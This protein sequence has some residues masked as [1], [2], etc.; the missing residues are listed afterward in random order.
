MLPISEGQDLQ[1]QNFFKY[2]K[3]R[4]VETFEEATEKGIYDYWLTQEDIADIARI[5]YN[6]FKNPATPDLFEFE[7]SGSISQLTEQIKQFKKSTHAAE[8]RL[9]LIVNLS[10]QHWVTLILSRHYSTYTGLY[11]DSQGNLLSAEYYAVLNQFNIK[12]TDFSYLAQQTDDYNCGLWA[13]ENAADLNTM[14]NEA[15]PFDWLLECFKRPRNYYYFNIVRRALLQKFYLDVA[16]R[17]RLGSY[18]EAQAGPTTKRLKIQPLEKDNVDVRL[19]NFV[20]SF[21]GYFMQ[22]L[23]AF[24]LIAR[25][26]KLTIAAL[27]QELKTGA[28]GA[29]FGL[30]I[31]R[32]LPGTLPSLVASLRTISSQYYISKAKARKITRAFSRMPLGALTAILADA[33]VEIFK[34]FEAQFMHVTDKA[35]DKLAMQK[36]AE[37]A[38]ARALNYVS[39]ENEVVRVSMSYITEAIILGNSDKYFDPDLKKFRLSILGNAIQDES[40]NKI[41]T[42]DLFEKVGLFV[43]GSSKKYYKKKP[44]ESDRYGYRCVLSWEKNANNVLIED[45]AQDYEQVI[46]PRQESGF[47]NDLQGYTYLLQSATIQSKAQSI[48]TKIKNAAQDISLVKSGIKKSIIFDLRLPVEN[49]VG[50]EAALNELHQTLLLGKTATIVNAMSG[51]SLGSAPSLE[52]TSG[53]Q[54]AVSGLGGIGKTQLA[55]RYAQ[56]HVTEYD[57]N[58]VWINS[59]T[60]LDMSRSFS[61]LAAKLAIERKDEYGEHK[62]IERIVEEIY[63]YFSDRRSLFI[64]DNVENY[65]EI[66]PFLPKSM[67][68]NKPSLLITSRYKNWQNAAPVVSLDVFTNQESLALV[69]NGLSINSNSQDVKIQLLH[70]LLHGLPLALQQAIAYIKIQRNLD[71]SFSIGNYI[72]MF[73]EKT[74]EVLDFNFRSYS[75]DP[76]LKTVYMTWKITLERIK[77]EGKAGEMAI[78]I[79]NI[80]SFIFPE[81]ISTETFSVFYESNLLNEA[82]HLL[83]VYSMTDAGSIPSE[84]VVHRLMQKVVNLHLE[85]NIA[86]FK[87][88][89]LQAEVLVMHYEKNMETRFHYIYF[90]LNIISHPELESELQVKPSFKQISSILRIADVKMWNYFLDVSYTKFNK[91]KY[92]EF[93]TEAFLNYRKQAV[94]FYVLN[95]LQYIEKK[96]AEEILSKKDIEA[97]LGDRYLDFK[98]EYRVNTL[99]TE[100]DKRKRQLYVI[101][102]ISEFKRKIF[103]ERYGQPCQFNRKKRSAEISC[104]QQKQAQKKEKQKKAIKHLENVGHIARFVSTGLFAKDTVAAILRGDFS[105]VAINFSLLL[106]GRFFGKLSNTLLAQ[107]EKLTAGESALLQKEFTLENKAALDIF[108]H[109]EVILS[110]KR[111]LLSNTIKMASPFIARGT[112]ILFAYNLITDIQKYKSGDT[113]ALSSIVSNGAIV[114]ID[115]AE[116]SVEAAEFLGIITGVSEFTGPV[117]EGIAVLIWL[118]AEGYETYKELGAIEKYVDLTLSDKFIQGSRVFFGLNP[119][120]YIELKAKN[121]QLIQ[122]AVSFL[123][124]HRDVKRYVFSASSTEAES[125]TRSEVHLDNKFNLTLS[126]SMPDVPSNT[127]LFCVSGTR[128]VTHLLPHLGPQEV[129]NRYFCKK[130]IGIEYSVNRTGDA[131]LIALDKGDDKAIVVS[132]IPTIFLVNTGNKVYKGNDK[133]NLFFLLGNNITGTLEGGNGI[134]LVLLNNFYADTNASTLIDRQRF[135][136][137]KTLAPYEII[138]QC[139]SLNK[140]ALKNINQIYG[141]PNK[142]DVLYLTKDITFVDGKGGESEAFPDIIYV[143]GEAEQGLK[144]IVSANTQV[145]YID[146]NL[147][148]YPVDHVIPNSQQGKAQIDFPFRDNIQPRFFFDYYFENL[149]AIAIDSHRLQ[150]NFSSEESVA[151][152]KETFSLTLQN[153]FTRFPSN[154]TTLPENVYYFFKEGIQIKLLDENHVYIKAGS[155]RKLDDIIDSFIVAANRL[156]KTFTI[157]LSHNQTVSIGQEKNEILITNCLSESYLI[158]NGGENVC[159]VS[160]LNTTSFPLPEVTLYDSREDGVEE[161]RDTLDLREV[162][163]KINSVCSGQ[164]LSTTLQQEGNDLVMR[165]NTFYYPVNQSQECVQSDVRWAVI[166]VRFKKAILTDWCQKIDVLLEDNKPQTIQYNTTKGWYLTGEAITFAEDKEIIV[167]TNKDIYQSAELAILKNVGNFTFLNKNGTDLI[168]TNVLDESTSQYDFYTIIFSRFYELSEMREKVLSLTFLFLDQEVSL[169]NYEEQINTTLSFSSVLNELRSVIPGPP[170]RATANVTDGVVTLDRDK[171]Q[172][173]SHV[174]MPVSSSTSATKIF[175]PFYGLFNW[176]MKQGSLLIS[177]V[178]NYISLVLEDANFLSAERAVSRSHRV[179]QRSVHNAIQEEN[180]DSPLE[181]LHR[182][183]KHNDSKLLTQKIKYQKKMTKKFHSKWNKFH[184]QEGFFTQMYDYQEAKNSPV[185]LKQQTNYKKALFLKRDVLFYQDS[186]FRSEKFLPQVTPNVDVNETLVFANYLLRA[187]QRN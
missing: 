155:S 144:I 146:S 143:T 6:Y 20:E 148:P 150:F 46:N 129:L 100:P 75:N 56:L 120:E 104:S 10:N 99:S 47:Q 118:G 88:V 74:K 34:S 186:H 160:P 4:A 78:E 133:G 72:E 39:E 41:Y 165:L 76:Y 185:F 181:N 77:K 128:T 44:V 168:I 172:V 123:K 183:T 112:S 110:G 33:A 32:S 54:A 136:C 31:S 27:K 149:T 38:V 18:S 9:T 82:M 71:S 50:R 175:S 94:P 60:K 116:A 80:M 65:V 108:L 131:T 59:E 8:N 176:A 138:P 113:R 130:A 141:R 67:V 177:S 180:R 70:N 90:L 26:E 121:N 174:E 64:F 170:Q 45:Y 158:S 159:V 87:S 171:R 42:A 48:L 11:I 73:K 126:E 96:M 79:L 124:E 105:G 28:T 17:E 97:V 179:A 140:V 119:S 127:Q 157:Q 137:A 102:R 43:E 153:S 125:H 115:G 178:N 66:E 14:L 106:S 145:Y 139:D 29:L 92:I 23:A 156:E 12:V 184:K 154:A 61:K 111:K 142:K 84:C 86:K 81:S 166:S 164:T 5:E 62:D 24:Q 51:M 22:K 117:G 7:I 103:P 162:V 13:L 107:G 57:N 15:K 58:V 132:Q 147:A 89:A 151:F 182:E 52:L 134:D 98:P 21:I 101:S 63:D 36:L 161:F 49:F 19:E 2:R 152:Q 85:S 91:K 93:L 95:M 30:A 163:K 187:M 109:E 1:V 114:A 69:K 53:A 55:L 83:R 68:G 167:I 16:R 37:D 25:G 3:K 122:H 173:N 169:K 35:G 40:E 135:L